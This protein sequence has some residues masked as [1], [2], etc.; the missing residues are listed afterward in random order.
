MMSGLLITYSRA[1]RIDDFVKIG[2]VE[3]TVMQIGALSTKVK[4][5]RGEEVT[6]PNAI[7]VANVTLKLVPRAR[8]YS[9]PAASPTTDSRAPVRHA[10]PSPPRRRAEGS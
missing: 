9:P 8:W 1:V 3:G 4:T 2:D 7:V 6:I 5:P 10:R